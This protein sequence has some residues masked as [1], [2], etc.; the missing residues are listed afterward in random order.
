MTDYSRETAYQ[1]GVRADHLI[2]AGRFL[3]LG[4]LLIPVLALPGIVVS[5]LAASKGR[6]SGGVTLRCL[7]VVMAVISFS[8]W[9]ALLGAIDDDTSSSSAPSDANSTPI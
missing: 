7:S 5:A 1:D 4:T 6:V 9:S 2:L 8:A 3:V